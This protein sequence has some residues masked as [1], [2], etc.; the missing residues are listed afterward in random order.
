MTSPAPVEVSRWIINGNELQ[1]LVLA[2]RGHVSVEFNMTKAREEHISFG[3]DA[4][5]V[6][7]HVA[8]LRGIIEI[9]EAALVKAADRG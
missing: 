6:R 5:R 8:A 3:G 1:G 7:A 4:A 2:E 9:V